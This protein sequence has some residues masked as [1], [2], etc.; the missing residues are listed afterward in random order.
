MYARIARFEGGTIDAIV[1][2]AG[3]VRRGFVA[4]SSPL[5]AARRAS[6]SRRS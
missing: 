4:A 1:A 6:T 2:E 3:D 5:A